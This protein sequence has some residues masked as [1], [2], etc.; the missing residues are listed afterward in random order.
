M[1]RYRVFKAENFSATLD[2]VVHNNYQ[3]FMVERLVLLGAKTLFRT[4]K[5]DAGDL[6]L[7]DEAKKKPHRLEHAVTNRS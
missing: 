1:F 6:S 5:E 7:S 2:P 4:W 3:L